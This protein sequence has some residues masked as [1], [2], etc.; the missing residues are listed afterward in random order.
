MGLG[1][2]VR[3]EIACHATTGLIPTTGNVVTCYFNPGV[4]PFIEV[5]N[6]DQVASGT[7][8]NILIPKLMNPSGDFRIN[9]SVLTTKSSVLREIAQK[10]VVLAL[11]T[12][13]TPTTVAAPTTNSEVAYTITN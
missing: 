13:G 5:L 3:T 12:P 9:V 6:F 8:I 2:T 1:F 7:A 4:D 11:V 10:I